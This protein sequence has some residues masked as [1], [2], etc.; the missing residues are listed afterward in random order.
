MITRICKHFASPVFNAGW[1]G[2]VL[3]FYG[4]PCNAFQQVADPDFKPVV[5]SPAYTEKSGPVVAIDE[6]HANFH[7]AGE[8]YKPFADLLRAD[9]YTVKTNQQPFSAES[10]EGVAVLVIANAGARQGSGEVTSAFTDAECGAVHDWVRGGGSLLLIADHAPFGSA[11]ENLGK[12]FGVTMGKG[13]V[14]DRNAEGNLTTQLVFSR[15]NGLLGDHPIIRGR[16]ESEA[17]QSVRSFTG[18]SLTVPAGATVLM[19]LGEQACEAADQP[20]LNAAAE[21]AKEA[22]DQ[23]LAESTKK[24]ASSVAGRAQGIAFEEGNGRVVVMA[25]AGMFSAQVATLRDGANQRQIKMGINVEGNDNQQ[26][27][28]NLMHWLSRLF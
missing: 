7:T 13:W 19:R 3:F 23:P 24:H 28:L 4:V 5:A 16:E 12:Q 21:A 17:V 27:A 2:G 15:E 25:E 9:G 26:F 14:F 10:L 20:A 18:Q 1:L 11:A 6:A 8:R 22:A